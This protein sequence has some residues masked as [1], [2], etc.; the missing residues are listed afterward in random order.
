MKINRLLTIIVIVVFMVG[1]VEATVS[2][3]S[4]QSVRDAVS[5][6]SKQVKQMFN[7]L[8]VLNS[9]VVNLK[10]TSNVLEQDIEEIKEDVSEIDLLKAELEELKNQ[11]SNQEIPEPSGSLMVVD[12]NG[13]EV[14]QLVE[15]GG[16][17]GVVYLEEL[18][19]F[20]YYEYKTGDPV[21]GHFGSYFYF[22]SDDCTG[23]RLLLKAQQNPFVYMWDEAADV[24]FHV[25]NYDM[26]DIKKDKFLNSQQNG[27]EGQTCYSVS[28][29]STL[30][31]GQIL[32]IVEEVAPPPSFEGPL[33][34]E[35][36]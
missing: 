7:K 1:F 28:E 16:K 2:D 22:E 25:P 31:G 10:E 20:I 6:L 9:E 30:F 26:F 18:E 36:K 17:T 3:S 34:I 11:I 29:N 8:N 27:W 19:R 15:I 33:T 21:F 5:K 32:S 14:G 4:F 12:A 24:Y 23:E 13:D 35:V